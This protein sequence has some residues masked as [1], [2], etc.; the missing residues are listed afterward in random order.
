MPRFSVDLLANTPKVIPGGN[1]LRITSTSAPVTVRYFRGSELQGDAAESVEAGYAGAPLR[2]PMAQ[3]GTPAFEYATLES[4]TAQTVVVL[5]TRGN[6]RYDRSVGI[7]DAA[8][9]LTQSAA[10]AIGYDALT[11]NGYSFQGGT[12]QP[13]V[14]AQVSAIQIKNPAASG[15]VLYLDSLIIVSDTASA[16][17]MAHYN[18]DLTTAD[19][20]L[21]NKNNSGAAASSRLRRQTT[22]AALTAALNLSYRSQLVANQAFAVPRVSPIRLAAGEGFIVE[23]QTVN[24][25]LDVSVEAREY[26]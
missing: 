26:S 3:P 11:Q 24:A 17:Q 22:A 9:R 1:E 8:P 21:Q 7:V 25:R 14:A 10:L 16:V 20:F 13:N 23:L 15:K 5:V 6:S 18:V 2:D 12:T 19:F 4:A